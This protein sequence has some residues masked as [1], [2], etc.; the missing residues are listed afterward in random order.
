MLRSFSLTLKK[1]FFD[2]LFKFARSISVRDSASGIV[3]NLRLMK[4]TLK[5]TESGLVFIQSI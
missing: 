2:E 5:V 3:M 4:R 1:H